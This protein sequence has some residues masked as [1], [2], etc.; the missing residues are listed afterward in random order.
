MDVVQGFTEAVKANSFSVHIPLVSRS[1]GSK[2]DMPWDYPG[3][4]WF[5]WAHRFANFYGWSLDYIAGLDVDVAI[6]L[7]QEM[8]VQDQLEKEWEW[9]LSERA[10]P[11]NSSTKKYE[12][13]PLSRPAWMYP[14]MKSK[15]KRIIQIP[16]SMMPV[17]NIVKRNGLADF[18]H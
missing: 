4:S 15:K 12:Y 18:K 6:K 3:R 1:F 13:K 17:G 7:L 2:E 5:A 16:K 9:G 14:E 10:F 11:Y 8:L